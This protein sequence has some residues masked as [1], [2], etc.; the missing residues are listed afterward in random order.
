MT[1]PNKCERNITPI[2][3]PYKGAVIDFTK[4]VTVP[5]TDRRQYAADIAAVIGGVPSKPVTKEARL[6]CF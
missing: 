1:V 3:T 4:T 6:N 2:A 5:S